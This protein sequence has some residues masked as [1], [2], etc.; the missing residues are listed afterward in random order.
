M[1]RM[2][3]SGKDQTLQLPR[4]QIP[5]ICEDLE[6][7]LEDLIRQTERGLRDWPKE[8][9]TLTFSRMFISEQFRFYDTFK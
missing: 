8:A 6:P 3:L 4:D 5:R 2:L 9:F 7:E 1:V